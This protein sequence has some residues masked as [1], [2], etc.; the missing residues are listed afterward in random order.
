MFDQSVNIFL[1]KLVK[2]HFLFDLFGDLGGT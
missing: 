1:E 2:V